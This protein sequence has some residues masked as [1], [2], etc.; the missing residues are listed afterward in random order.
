MQ[1]Y[2]IKIAAEHILAAEQKHILTL[3][4]LRTWLQW[5]YFGLSLVEKLF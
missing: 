2:K 3:S 5:Q 1:E 4:M